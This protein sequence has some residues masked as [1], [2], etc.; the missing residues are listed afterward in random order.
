MQVQYALLYQT[1]VTELAPYII[2]K[3]N[4]LVGV[5]VKDVVITAGRGGSRGGM[6]GMHSLPAIFK[7]VF[8]EYN[9]IFL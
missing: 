6:W 5:V 3:P 4:R 7:H 8:D 1:T 2:L 9:T